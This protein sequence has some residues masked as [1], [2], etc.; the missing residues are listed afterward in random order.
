M[1]ASHQILKRINQGDR[2]HPVLGCRALLENSVDH[3]DLVSWTAALI[4]SSAGLEVIDNVIAAANIPQNFDSV[5]TL[6]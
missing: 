2:R 4:Q 5:G 3:E 6:A 1:C